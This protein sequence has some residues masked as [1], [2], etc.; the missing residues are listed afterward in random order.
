VKWAHAKTGEF[1]QTSVDIVVGV[2]NPGSRYA[3]TR[4]NLGFDVV[5]VL[6][7]RYDI[8]MQQRLSEAVCGQ[9]TI[10]QRAVLLVKPQTYMNASGRAVAPLVQKYMGRG[11]RLVVI[12]DDIDLPLGRVK[13]KRHGGDA[14]HL[15]VRSII[16]CLGHGEFLRLRMGIGRP[17]CSAHIV[18][19]V[20]SSFTAAERQTREEMI[21]QAVLCVETL[22]RSTP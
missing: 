9:G 1:G 13:I 19:Y 8:A 3:Q 21:A 15:G 5:D 22:L 10:S 16:A 14:G 11:D 7:R 6:A 12:H 18:D 17:A 4:H 20:L 2:G